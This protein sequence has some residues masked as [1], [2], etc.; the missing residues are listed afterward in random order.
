MTYNVFSGTLSPTQ[1]QSVVTSQS[2]LFSPLNNLSLHVI[3]LETE[4]SHIH[5]ILLLLSG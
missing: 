5:C 3:G 1:L 4:Y 2:T